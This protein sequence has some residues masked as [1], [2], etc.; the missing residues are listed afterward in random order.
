M[1]ASFSKFFLGLNG[2]W[3]LL[4]FRDTAG[5]LF[6]SIKFS[7]PVLGQ[8]VF[9][10]LQ[11]ANTVK[12]CSIIMHMY[13]PAESEEFTPLNFFEHY[14]SRT[15]N[16]Q[17]M[18]YRHIWRPTPNY[19]V[20][21]NF[22]VIEVMPYYEH[23]PRAFSLESPLYCTNLIVKSQWPPNSPNFNHLTTNACGAMLQTF[24]KFNW[25]PLWS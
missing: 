17:A 20:S 4:S 22:K 3:I 23:S 14:F 12:Y 7:D 10:G 1:C 24:Y 21:F 25:R 15:D 5:L 6:D 2:L 9:A 13:R 11:G 8:L 19:K 16:F 18:F